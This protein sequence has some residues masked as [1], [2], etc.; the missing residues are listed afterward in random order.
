MLVVSALKRA[1]FLRESPCSQ[2]AS[3][4]V[5]GSRQRTRL[6]DAPWLHGLFLKLLRA[7][8]RS[9]PAMSRI[10][11]VA[12]LACTKFSIRDRVRA[13]SQILNIFIWYYMY[14]LECVHGRSTAVG[15]YS[16]ILYLNCKIR[17]RKIFCVGLLYS[18]MYYSCKCSVY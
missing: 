2:G 3:W 4:A 13:S 9:G 11:R 8:A 12:V 6:P 1:K 18:N 5:C 15:S 17:M 16:C 10:G 7:S 14:V